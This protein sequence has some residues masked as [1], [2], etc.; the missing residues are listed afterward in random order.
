[1]GVESDLVVFFFSFLGESTPRM[2]VGHFQAQ[3]GRVPLENSFATRTQTSEES[4]L[5]PLE[6]HIAHAR[7]RTH[8]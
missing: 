2:R 5:S 8:A 4:E 6:N 1:M 3:E 7:T